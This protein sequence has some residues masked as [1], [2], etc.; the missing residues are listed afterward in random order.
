M[1][2][3]P[4]PTPDLLPCPEGRNGRT[5][6]PCLYTEPC[7]PDCT[8][9]TA[10]SSAGCF[11]C[12]SYGS[13]EQRRAKAE[14]LAAKIDR[15]A[16]VPELAGVRERLA[17][18][19]GELEAVEWAGSHACSFDL[20]EPASCCPRCGGIKPG[21]F[22]RISDDYSEMCKEG[23]EPDCTLDAGVRKDA[24]LPTENQ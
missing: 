10:Y 18:V 16:I 8:C 11:R 22:D 14:R 12:C 24:G 19:E 7:R 15:D 20:K 13:P 6:C 3:A 1:P 17:G 2:T 5:S 23:H 4:S 9:V 21:E